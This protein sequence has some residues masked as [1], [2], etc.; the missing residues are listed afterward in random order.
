MQ[1]R[2]RVPLLVFALLASTV[3]A[4]AS[5]EDEI[6]T[7]LGPGAERLPNGHWRIPLE[8]GTFLTT[9]G[10]D[11]RPNHGSAIDLFDEERPLL[12]ATDY[13]QHVLYG[14]P[15]SAPNRLSV[16]KSQIQAAMRR[17]NAVLNEESLISGNQSADYKVKCD[18]DG[19][20]QVD[21]FTARANSFQS[22]VNDAQL[23][24]FTATNADYSIFY[25]ADGGNV[26]GT[27]SFIQDEQLSENNFNNS[28]GDYAVSYNDCWNNATPM[29]ENGHNQG[30]V[31]NNAPYS[32]GSGAHCADENDVMCYVDGGDKNQT[33]V[34]RCTDRMHFDCGNDTYFDSEPE[35]GEYLSAN[36]N[37]G[38]KLNRFIQFGTPLSNPPQAA[39][40]V[41]CSGLTCAF[42]DASTDDG[43]IVSWRWEFGDYASSTAQNPSRTYYQDGLY[44]VTLTVRDEN[45]GY[46]MASQRVFVPNNGDPDTKTPNLTNNVAKADRSETQ[47]RWKYYKIFVPSGRPSLTVTLDGPA[48][49]ASVLCS[50]D[51]DLYVRPGEWPATTAY[52]CRPLQ[53]S[54]DETCVISLPRTGYWYVGVYAASAPPP[55]HTI[56]LYSVN[57]TIKGAY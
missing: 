16:V 4:A 29:H 34:D 37:I 49:A 24:G 45:G 32:T 57:Y 27:G 2:A 15:Q 12:C 46:G 8:S 23:A 9:H 13:Y 55:V 14:R 56:N 44:T 35:L 1:I 6:M 40:L 21:T 43:S 38:S 7:A 26:C 47:G 20:I 19:E 25:D 53:P 52:V 41:S 48:C 28:G 11:Y 54:N 30:A 10:P 42:T 33:V 51:L 22:I 39:L 18:V 36:W 31:Q 50:T 3:S 5:A 17:M